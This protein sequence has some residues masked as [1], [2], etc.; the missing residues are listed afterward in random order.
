LRAIRTDDYL[1]MR[2][3][4]PDRWPA[5]TPDFERAFIYP[6]WYADTDAGPTKH[7]M[8]DHRHDDAVHE[9]LFDLAFAKRPGDELYDLKK[10]PDQLH[11]VAADPAYTQTK[12]ELW[13]RL[14]GAL[15]ETGDPRVRGRGDLFDM[16]PYTGGIV[17]A[18]GL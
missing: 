3:F 18:R 16:Q 8:V 2:N 15:Q 4:R 6:A 13:N 10:D 7:Y 5:G 11:N 12:K 17:R 9:R 1:Y 14:M